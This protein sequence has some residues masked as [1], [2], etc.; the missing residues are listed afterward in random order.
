VPDRVPTPANL[1]LRSAVRRL[2]RVVYQLIAERRAQGGES[3]DVLGLLIEARDEDD[4]GRMTD[5]QLRDEIMTLLLAGHETTAN[6]LVWVWYLLA[7]HRD[8]AQR[9]VEEVDEALGGRPA[10]AADVP[11]LAF[12]AAVVQE[13]LRLYPPSWGIT[14]QA[15]EACSVAGY[16]VAKGTHVAICQWIVHRD[17][18]WYADPERFTPERWANGLAGRPRYAYFPFGGGQRQC[19]GAGFAM[20]ELV[21]VVATLA[22]RFS[23][24]PASHAEAVPLASVTLRPRD[25]VWM[26][27]RRRG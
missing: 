19:I 4:G 18:R 16:P 20:L 24:A 25:R 14:R 17:G 6:A 1:R 11:N 15:E 7:R 12:T 26:M 22:Q 10:E 13:A 9:L 21:L 2:D 3:D 5:R 23:F 27:V 8:A